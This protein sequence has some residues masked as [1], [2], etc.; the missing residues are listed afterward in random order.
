[1]SVGQLACRQQT[2]GSGIEVQ[3]CIAASFERRCTGAEMDEAVVAR[4]SAASL[5]DED[6]RP[7]GIVLGHDQGSTA[8]I[9]RSRHP[10]QHLEQRRLGKG[11][12]TAVCG[13]R[14]WVAGVGST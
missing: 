6:D 14:R 10:W 9:T 2:S 8:W 4:A 3:A 7:M 13:C 5:H 1:M 11:A 12:L